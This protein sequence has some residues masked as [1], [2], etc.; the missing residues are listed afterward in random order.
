MP[1]PPSIRASITGLR[2]DL[3]ALL[4]GMASASQLKSVIRVCHANAAGALAQRGHL[5]R[6]ADLHGLNLTDLAFDCI[7]DLFARDESGKYVA[8]ESYFSAYD[9]A[10]FSDEDAY[11]HLQ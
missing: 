4:E 7:S 11:F 2:S 6:L 8:L 10:G 3:T 5:G 9:V 1:L